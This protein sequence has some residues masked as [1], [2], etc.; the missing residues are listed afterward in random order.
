MRSTTNRYL[1][2]RQSNDVAASSNTLHAP[3]RTPTRARFR[4]KYAAN[5]QN[6][7]SERCE[8][9]RRSAVWSVGRLRECVHLRQRCISLLHKISPYRSASVFSKELKPVVHDACFLAGDSWIRFYHQL[10]TLKT[11]I[12]CH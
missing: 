8:V 6:V 4:L 1:F 12:V 5:G 3:C 11:S 7:K 10:S 2:G 9:S